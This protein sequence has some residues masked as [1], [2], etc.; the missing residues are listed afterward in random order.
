MTQNIK[1]SN[2]YTLK[3]FNEVDIDPFDDRDFLW[4]WVSNHRDFKNKTDNCYLP[5]DEIRE[6]FFKRYENEGASEFETKNYY[7]TAIYAYIHRGIT[8][9]LTPFNDRWDSGIAYVAYIDKNVFR[10]KFGKWNKKLAMKCLEIDV[11]DVDMW[12]NG[13]VYGFELLDKDGDWI[14]GG[15]G[16]YGKEALLDYLKNYVSEIPDDFKQIYC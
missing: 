12:F 9:S 2:G 3:I 11:H 6:L 7:M 10:H 13:E 15:C 4:D 14:D 8:I 5:T 16:F 1:L